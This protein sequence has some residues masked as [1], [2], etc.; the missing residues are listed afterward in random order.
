MDNDFLTIRQAAEYLGVSIHTMRHYATNRVFP[1]YRSGGGKLLFVEKS[2]LTK[3][4]QAQRIE[5]SAKYERV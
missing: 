4:K 5:R 2:E 1:M 3:W